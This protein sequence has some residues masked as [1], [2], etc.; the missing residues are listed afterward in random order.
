MVARGLIVAGT[1]AASLVGG[2][3]DARSED[4]D[5]G[6]RFKSVGLQGNPLGFAIG[7][8]SADIEYLPAPHHALHLTPVGTYAL[9]GTDDQLTGFGAEVGY[10]WYSGAL[11][12]HGVFVG[13]SFLAGELEYI[14]GAVVGLPL[15][16]PD[17]T[18]YVSLG[19]ALDAG[20]QVIVL[21]NLAVGAGAGVQYTIDTVE[22]HFEYASHPWHDLLFGWG[23]RPR[24]LLSVGAA[25]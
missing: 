25:F 22:P 10:R 5:D 20:Y 23:L 24:A 14:H 6:V 8:Y 16:Q 18:K 21:G 9:P 13:G 17:D 3:R 2:Q 1:L 4:L 11:G 12:P 7:R 15:D 19:G